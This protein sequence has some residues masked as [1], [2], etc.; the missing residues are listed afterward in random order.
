MAGFAQKPHA[1]LVLFLMAFVE[2]SLFPIAP[3]FLFIPL[4]VMRPRR[5]LWYA[6]I[7]VLG[8]TVG[9]IVGYYI[10]FGLFEILG[11]QILGF[12]GWTEL[13]QAVLE[14]YRANAW[15]SLL[16]AGFTPIPFQ[17]FA[18]AAGFRQTIDIGTFALA[19]L[20]GR[21]LRFFF[22]GGLL[23]L[24]GGKV[25]ELLDNHLGWVSVVVLVLF[26]LWILS[27]RI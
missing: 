23:F 15:S 20:A 17:V 8:S 26:I 21:S 6:A 2:S 7:C 27:A 19:V 18:L 9:A 4:S 11:Q 24:F 3:D 10:G 14:K 1:T 5:S 22:L 16:L 25:K 12:F 13:F